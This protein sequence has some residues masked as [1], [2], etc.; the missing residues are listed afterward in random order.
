MIRRILEEEARET[1]VPPDMVERI[2]KALKAFMQKQN[3]KV[4]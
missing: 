2:L 1:V 4:K 3:K